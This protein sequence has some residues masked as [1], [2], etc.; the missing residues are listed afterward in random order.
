MKS[1]GK[2]LLWAALAVAVFVFFSI[3]PANVGTVGG[4]PGGIVLYIIFGGGAFC[5]LL[6]LGLLLIAF[7]SKEAPSASKVKPSIRAV[8]DSPAHTAKPWGDLAR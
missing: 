5:S 8:L 6:F 1:L 7:S 2:L 3:T 4:A